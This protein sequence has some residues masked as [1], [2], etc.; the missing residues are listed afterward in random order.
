MKIFKNLLI[1]ITIFSMLSTFSFSQENYEKKD[2]KIVAYCSDIFKDP[3]DTNV[4]Y[5]KLTHVIYAFL[6]PKEDA[7]LEKPA[8]PAE[9]KIM[10]QKAHE[11]NKKAMIA[12]GGWSYKNIPLQ[13]V[14]EKISSDEKLRAKFIANVIEFLKE[15]NLDGLDLDWEHPVLGKTEKNYEDFVLDLS[16]SLK[17]E[18]KLFSA[19]LNGAWS[20]T[21]GP[22]ASLAVSE[23]ALKEFDWINIMAYDMNNEDH[24]PYWF[25]ETSIQYW[26]NRGV[27]ENKIVLGVPFYARPSFKQ[28]RDIVFENKLNAYKDFNGVDYY[29]G[30]STIKEKTRLAYKEAGGIMIFDVNEDT[31][32]DLSLTK[33]IKDEL[34]RQMNMSNIDLNKQINIIVDSNEII[35]DEKSLGEP[36]LDENNRI[37]VPV[38]KTLEE[39]GASVNFDEST[40]TVIAKKLDKTIRIKID[41]NLIN[42]N[43]ENKT[44][45]TKAEVKDSRVY[46]PL[47]YVYES[48]GYKVDWR[49]KTRTAI[50]KPNIL[51][52]K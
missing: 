35:F 39:I 2:F 37:L 49:T 18:N 7:T 25:A 30:I 27:K 36:Y 21:K 40:K 41:E 43:G 31:K 3:I 20:D 10:V 9:I 52:S 22:D 19:A 8:D 51:V 32:D 17:K 1:S 42:I 50:V 14:F 15:Y 5:D 34:N 44:M 13:P 46:I 33:A 47:R 48:F 24:S 38:R 28:Y 45:D 11:Q 23:K 6:I 26:K 4:P 12:L 16:K 29:N